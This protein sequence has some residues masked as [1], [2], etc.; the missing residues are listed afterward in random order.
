[1]SAICDLRES[2]DVGEILD[3][4]DV[5][6]AREDV[7]VSRCAREPVHG[8]REAA[9]QGVVDALGIE[10]AHERVEFGVE[11]HAWGF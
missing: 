9:T 8:Q 2:S 1:M 3:A 6:A 4:V 10:P 5:D 7:D 11:V